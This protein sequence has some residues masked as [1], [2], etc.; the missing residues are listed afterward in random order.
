[1]IGCVNKLL[2][3]LIVAKAGN[4]G[5]GQGKVLGGGKINDVL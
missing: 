1:M 3:T 4:I 2:V 5:I